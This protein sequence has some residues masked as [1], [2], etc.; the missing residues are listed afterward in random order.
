MSNWIDMDIGSDLDIGDDPNGALGD[1]PAGGMGNQIG[2]G[3]NIFRPASGLIGTLRYG[4]SKEFFVDHPG[5]SGIDVENI[6]K[7]AGLHPFSATYV[8]D[9][10][11]AMRLPNKEYQRGCQV[12]ESHELYPYR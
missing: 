7:D 4:L 12:L 10:C 2:A 1:G 3:F 6:L 11:V 8:E 5:M 9:G